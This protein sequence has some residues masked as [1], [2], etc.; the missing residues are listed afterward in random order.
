M[1]CELFDSFLEYAGE[2]RTYYCIKIENR[3]QFTRRVTN[4][5]V[6]PP[7]EARNKCMKGPGLEDLHNGITHTT[8]N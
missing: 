3:V 5:C 2:L 7:K 4:P 6:D 1:L 8:N